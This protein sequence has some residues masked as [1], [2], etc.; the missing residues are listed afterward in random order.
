ME[1]YMYGFQ[2]NI[3]IHAFESFTHTSP[4]DL[5]GLEWTIPLLNCYQYNYGIEGCVIIK[6]FCENEIV[7]NSMELWVVHLYKLKTTII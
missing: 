5:L 6:S 3:Y 2:I 1:T 4:L 7:K